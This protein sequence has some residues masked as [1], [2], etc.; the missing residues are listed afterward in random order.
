MRSHVVARR[1]VA[2]QAIVI[3]PRGAHHATVTGEQKYSCRR[4]G[5]HVS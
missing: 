2:A 5:L 3:A 1:I 4:A